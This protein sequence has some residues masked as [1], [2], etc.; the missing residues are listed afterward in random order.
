V[1]L[2][3]ALELEVVAEGIESADE[4]EALRELNCEF[5]QGFYLAEPLD[6]AHEPVPAAIGG[7]DDRTAA[8]VG[9]GPQLG[10]ARPL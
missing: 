9:S 4:L 6:L 3:R 5:G 2:A 10:S 7:L 8:G 1:E